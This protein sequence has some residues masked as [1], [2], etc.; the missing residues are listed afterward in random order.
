M[1]FWE[2]IS[3]F[4]TIWK[5]CWHNFGIKNPLKLLN[6]AIPNGIKQIS[7][8]GIVFIEFLGPNWESKA[9]QSHKK[10]R[11]K[12]GFPKKHSFKQKLSSAW[13]DRRMRVGQSKGQSRP[14]S[15]PPS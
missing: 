5:S 4:D 6:I 2:L 10:K 9:A 11:P 12:M 14:F 8:F 3:K 1:T 15:D 13:A 7:D